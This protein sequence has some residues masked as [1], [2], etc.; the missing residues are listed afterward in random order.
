MKASIAGLVQEDQKRHECIME[1]VRVLQNHEK[2]ILQN[3]AASQEMAQ[4]VKVL[5]QARSPKTKISCSKF[6]VFLV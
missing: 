4:Y 6:T 5:I 3:C 2:H 1:V